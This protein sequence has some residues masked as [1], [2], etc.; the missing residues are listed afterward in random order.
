MRLTMRLQPMRSM[1]IPVLTPVLVVL[2]LLAFVGRGSGLP[3][4]LLVTELV[5]ETSR[6]PTLRLRLDKN[7]MDDMQRALRTRVYEC[8]GWGPC[9]TASHAAWRGS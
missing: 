7:A 5:S 1:L 8:A 3:E 6:L 4:D 9:S 2:F